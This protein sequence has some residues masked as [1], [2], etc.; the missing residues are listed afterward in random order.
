MFQWWY[1]NLDAALYQSSAAGVH[2]KTVG[3][4]P[5]LHSH[6]MECCTALP[7]WQ[8]LTARNDSAKPGNKHRMID[9]CFEPKIICFCSIFFLFT[10]ANA[11]ATIC[12]CRKNPCH[13]WNMEGTFLLTIK[14]QEQSCRFFSR[15]AKCDTAGR[16]QREKALRKALMCSWKQLNN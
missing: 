11:S 4:L 16:W 15:W 1:L 7:E 12:C 8:P 13:H 6:D 9:P 14:T 2:S 10:Q 5:V 3:M